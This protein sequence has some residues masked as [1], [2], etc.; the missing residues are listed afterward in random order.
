MAAAN[1]WWGCYLAG[2]ARNRIRCNFARI[3]ERQLHL[4]G[5]PW[6]TL[7]GIHL[8]QQLSKPG[9]ACSTPTSTKSSL[10]RFSTPVAGSAAD[11]E[12]QPVQRKH[13]ER[14]FEQAWLSC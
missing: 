3:A 8:S 12:L 11:S 9:S 14:L 4:L 13:V 10:S 1:I 2:A 5:L 6:A 7:V